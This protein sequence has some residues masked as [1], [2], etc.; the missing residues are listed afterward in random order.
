M[1]DYLERRLGRLARVVEGAEQQ[2]GQP[3]EVVAA[4]L[5]GGQLGADPA[6]FLL[7]VRPQQS[8]SPSA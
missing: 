6:E 2:A 7:Q 1:Q 3:D 8:M 4:G 5:G